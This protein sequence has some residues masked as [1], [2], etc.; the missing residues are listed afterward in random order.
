MASAK[1]EQHRTSKFYQAVW[2]SI[3][4]YYD[5][6]TREIAGARVT[7]PTHFTPENWRG[8]GRLT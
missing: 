7:L 5:I 4:V 3:V 8:N 2:D 6:K 1:R